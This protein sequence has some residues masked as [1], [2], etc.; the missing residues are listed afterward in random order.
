MQKHSKLKTWAALRILTCAIL[1]IG[2]A[3]ADDTAKIALLEARI[4]KLEAAL[5]LAQNSASS[6]A[7]VPVAKPLVA[8]TLPASA[9]PAMGLACLAKFRWG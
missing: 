2:A 3:L 9:A 4:E 7:I 8:A 5:N 6:M 1:P